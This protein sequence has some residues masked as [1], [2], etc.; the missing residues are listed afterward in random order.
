MTTTSISP[1]ALETISAT[2]WDKNRSLR[3]GMITLTFAM[4]YPISG[5]PH[6]YHFPRPRFP[7]RRPS[8]PSSGI[9]LTHNSTAHLAQIQ[10]VALRR[11]PIAKPEGEDRKSTR[12]N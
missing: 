3:E 10:V 5:Q 6:P 12:L 9:P 8:A 4:L 1:L 11:L 7:H 2:V